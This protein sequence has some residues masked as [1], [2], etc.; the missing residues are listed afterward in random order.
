MIQCP[1]CFNS[2]RFSSTLTNY[3]VC[4]KCNTLCKKVGSD[5]VRSE[6]YKL[7]EE[8][9]SPLKLGALGVLT[10]K[11]FQIIGRVRFEYNDSHFNQWVMLFNDGKM[12]FLGE[13][14]G[15][16][17]VYQMDPLGISPKQLSSLKPGRLI[18]LL[19]KKKYVVTGLLDNINIICEGEIPDLPPQKF[20]HIELSGDDKAFAA[21]NVY[22]KERIDVY[23]GRY[24]EFEEF[25]FSQIKSIHEW[26]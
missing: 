6:A 9:M 26:E 3:I 17:A 16:Y 21:V 11:K 7:L 2:I 24:F 18:T 1:N 4:S 12:S 23:N 22:S 10:G 15:T 20:I 14:C 8:D 19:N 5:V 13:Y 25:N